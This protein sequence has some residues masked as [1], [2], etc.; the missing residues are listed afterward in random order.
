MCDT[1]D[2]TVKSALGEVATVTDLVV[3]RITWEFDDSVSFMWQ[4]KNPNFGQ[5]LP[6]WADTWMR[7]YGNGADMTTFFGSADTAGR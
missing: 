3:R 1:I 7:E 4:S 6:D 5:Q 2:G